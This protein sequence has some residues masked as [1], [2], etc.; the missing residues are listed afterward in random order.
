MKT[1][2]LT[3]LLALVICAPSLSAGG[4]MVPQISVV[5]WAER[6]LIPDRMDWSIQVR[7][8]GLD[9]EEVATSH[10]EQVK[11]A[12]RL[13]KDEGI[14]E[15]KTQTSR[16]QLQEQWEWRDGTRYR[17]GYFASTDVRFESSDF[18]LYDS[19]WTGLSTLDNV[20][21]ENVVLGVEDRRSIENEVRIDA[22]KNAQTQARALAE[23]IG[24][25]VG[26]PLLIQEDPDAASF[27][28]P[29]VMM[30]RAMADSESSDAALAPGR[31][32]VSAEIHATF[33]LVTSN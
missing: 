3:L 10:R 25:Q 12:L 1:I 32:S 4:S 6:E 24:A 5:G 29:K 16:M 9:V 22:L 20:S 8:E 30:A 33:R 23:A 13:L 18:G 17:R 2:S 11:A 15:K 19:L 7:T 31:I 14:E 21:V 28:Q 26:E 27:P